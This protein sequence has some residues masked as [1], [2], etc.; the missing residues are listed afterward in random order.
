M[1]MLPPP[2]FFMTAATFC[3]RIQTPRTL[4]LNIWSHRSIGNSSVGAPQL[5]PALLTRMSIRENSAST[6]RIMASI[7]SGFPMS[8]ATGRTRTPKFRRISS[9]AASRFFILRDAR[10]RSAPAS[11]SPSAMNFPIPRPPPVTSATFPPSRNISCSLM[12]TSSRRI[13]P[14]PAAGAADR[15]A[16][17]CS[18]VV[19][20][21]SNHSSPRRSPTLR[22]R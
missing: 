5:A 14:L 3:E 15:E 4:T 12:T 7:S 9:A 20:L 8:H 17:H 10:T 21:L 13:G 16:A 11:A 1:I 18:G 2:W 19:F 22:H 6:V